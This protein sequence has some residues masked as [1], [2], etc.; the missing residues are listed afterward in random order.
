MKIARTT[1]ARATSAALTNPILRLAS[2]PMRGAYAAGERLAPERALRAGGLG[3]SEV[4]PLR[5]RASRHFS[6]RFGGDRQ[7]G[8]LRSYARV[9][10][11]SLAEAPVLAWRGLGGFAAERTIGVPLKDVTAAVW[12][13]KDVGMPPKVFGYPRPQLGQLGHRDQSHCVGCNPFPSRACKGCSATARVARRLA[14][15]CEVRAGDSEPGARQ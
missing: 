2:R 9:S 6:L 7:S 3:P 15:G 10:F 12:A 5:L 8:R 11:S 14:S 13:L 4:A 1:S